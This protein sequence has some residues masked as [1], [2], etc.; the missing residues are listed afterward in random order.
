MFCFKILPC[1]KRCAHDW[2]TCPFAHP[3]EKARRRDPRTHAYLAIPC[4]EVKANQACPRGDACQYS[5]SV[6]EFWA[7]P[8]R[9]RTQLC[10]N[11]TSCRRSVCFFAH[12][13]A[14]LRVPGAGHL[15]HAGGAAAG[16]SEESEMAMMTP[17]RASHTGS[18]GSA[19]MQVDVGHAPLTPA[20]DC[21]VPCPSMLYGSLPAQQVPQHVDAAAAAA[22]AVQAAYSYGAMVGAASAPG[23]PFVAAAAAAA[24]AIEAARAGGAPARSGSLTSAASLLGSG[25][26]GDYPMS[27]PMSPT[28]MGGVGARAS[29]G[30]ATCSSPTSSGNS[31]TMAGHA[32]LVGGLAP[33]S[34]PVPKPP[35]G[36]GGA[37]RRR[38]SSAKPGSLPQAPLA[39]QP[40]LAFGQPGVGAPVPLPMCMP[41]QASFPFGA[42]S[43]G[44]PPAFAAGG[45]ASHMPMQ[46]LAPG[47]G[48]GAGMATPA[49]LLAAYQA[50][51]TPGMGDLAGPANSLAMQALA[52]MIANKQQQLQLADAQAML[53]ASSAQTVANNQALLG[54]VNALLQ[55]VQ[56]PP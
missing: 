50:L 23:E 30:G 36:A 38:H 8:A 33:G 19:A 48:A 11:G 18:H 54:L 45:L 40:H 9:Y 42:V 14:E 21:E 10:Q 7:H 51:A 16:G 20:L 17:P 39:Q 6:F 26:L 24:L 34:P 28:T 2:T 37:M 44:L 22:A 5:H 56:V 35:G 4:P 32:A 55:Q 46:A 52:G 31:S 13:L 43:A 41:G 29:L 15:K 25:Q 27:P 1:S 12:T 49:A 47:G 53:A 3:G